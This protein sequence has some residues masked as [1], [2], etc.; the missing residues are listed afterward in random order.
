MGTLRSFETATI[1]TNA[2]NGS[3]SGLVPS[4]SGFTLQNNTTQI[5]IHNKHATE[6]LYIFCYAYN[7]DSVLGVNLI[8]AIEITAG[9]YLTLSL[10]QR[11]ES[12]GSRVIVGFNT[13]ASSFDF[14]L[15]EIMGITN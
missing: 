2:T 5:I 15:T 13:G 3:T 1:A 10:G 9:A 4:G 8:N 6:T 12:V 11:S 14:K 7:T